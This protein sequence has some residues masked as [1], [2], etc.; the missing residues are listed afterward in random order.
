MSAGQTVILSSAYQRAQ[1]KRLIDLAPDRAVVNV[2][3]ATR[4][5]DQNN[6]MHALL[7]EVA[8]AKPGGR[9]L[10]T[11]DWKCL[12][13]SAVGH[14]VRF[15]PDLD[16]DGVVALGFRSSHLTKAEMGELIDFIYAWSAEHGVVLTDEV[17]R[18][19][20]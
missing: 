5:N 14:K 2:R 16:G 13:M 11:D 18:D 17:S 19:A 12:F 4:T 15:L 20:A 9:V 3:E 7:S 6:L 10:K 8:R 1:A